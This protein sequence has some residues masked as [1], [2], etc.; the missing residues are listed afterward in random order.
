MTL[1]DLV[2]D[3]GELTRIEVP[4]KHADACWDAIENA[5]KTRSF[6]TPGWFD[7]CTASYMGMILERVNMGRVV[8]TL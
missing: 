2:M 6:F 8:A 4:D 1:I 7:G 3:N 5:M